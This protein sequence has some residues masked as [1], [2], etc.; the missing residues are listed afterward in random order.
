MPVIAHSGANE[1]KFC[2][3]TEISSN[4]GCSIV[5]QIYRPRILGHT[6]NQE[7]NLRKYFSQQI[8]RFPH[9]IEGSSPDV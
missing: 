2:V 4:K 8:H 1:S 3:T 5:V 6:E 7:F 9:I